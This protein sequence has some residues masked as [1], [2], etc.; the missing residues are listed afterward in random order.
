[1]TGYASFENTIW[2][3]LTVSETVLQGLTLEIRMALSDKFCLTWND[4]KDSL[5]SEVGSLRNGEDFSDVTLV[6]EDTK[7]QAHRLVLTASSPFFNSVLKMMDHPKPMIY[8]KGTKVKDMEAVLDFIYKGEATVLKEDL[9]TFMALAEELELNGLSKGYT[10]D[11]EVVIDLQKV[12]DKKLKN[13]SNRGKSKELPIKEET[14]EMSDIDNLSPSPDSEIKTSI[15]KLDETIQSMMDKDEET[16]MFSCKVCGKMSKWR[17]STVNHIETKHIE[18]LLHPCNH[19]SKVNKSRDGLRQHIAAK[20]SE[21]KQ[22]EFNPHPCNL[23]EKGS[24]SKDGLRQH[25]KAKH[26]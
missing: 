6:C 13:Q 4:F 24:K 10:E 21:T 15:E 7:I 11:H 18:G 12:K 25:I 22:F 23:C 3:K 8:M 26:M 9:E 5:A 20:H 16:N 2:L 19:C 17:L 14:N 1:M